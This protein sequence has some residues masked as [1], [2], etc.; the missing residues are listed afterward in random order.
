ME[1]CVTA[2]RFN[3]LVI[4]VDGEGL[5]VEI[6]GSGREV[7]C[8]EG[9]REPRGKGVL[10]VGQCDEGVEDCMVARQLDDEA[11]GR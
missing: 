11:Y 7:V 1:R 4:G 9:E 3:A 6:C 5:L 8:A 10:G 2:G